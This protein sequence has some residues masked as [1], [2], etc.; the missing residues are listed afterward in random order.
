[1]H[2]NH[3]QCDW[4]AVLMLI[5]GVCNYTRV[6]VCVRVCA[7]YCAYCIVIVECIIMN[8]NCVMFL[9]KDAE[10]FNTNLY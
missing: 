5:E 6:C 4:Y 2:L 1:M 9:A 7:Q 3:T 8:S 10:V